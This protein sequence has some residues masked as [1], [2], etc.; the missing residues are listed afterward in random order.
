[1]DQIAALNVHR[2][3]DANTQPTK[4]RWHISPCLM[5]LAPIAAIF[6]GP[7]DSAIVGWFG[8]IDL[9]GDVE[10]T[11]HLSEAFAHGSGVAAIFITILTIDANRRREILKLLC[12]VIVVIVIANL[13][14][15]VVAR[16][17][18]NSFPDIT[19]TQSN[20]SPEIT[21]SGWDSSV[22]SFPSGHAATAVAMAFALSTLYPRG[23]W[24]F[25]VLAALACVQR[26]AA[27]AH[28]PTDVLGG[29]A[30]AAGFFLIFERLR[31]V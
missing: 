8:T 21:Q 15:N 27:G 1:M 26:I 18:P 19:Q 14:K 24:V 3:E 5:L 7:Y 22:R 11:I 20:W 13:A 28:Y 31:K 6:I 2:L 9:P 30:I 4:W 17:R 25:V 16:A 29:I 12:M 10:K 23:R